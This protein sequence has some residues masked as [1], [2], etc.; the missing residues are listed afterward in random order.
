MQTLSKTR[1]RKSADLAT[2]PQ[3]DPLVALANISR[4]QLAQL[5]G[6]SKWTLRYWRKSGWGPRAIRLGPPSLRR[7]RKI[8]FRRE[9]VA[10]YL[11]EQAVAPRRRKR[12]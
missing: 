2:E 3:Q 9:D 5:L 8:R 1:R 6:V 12:K 10:R 7:A 4:N 11:E